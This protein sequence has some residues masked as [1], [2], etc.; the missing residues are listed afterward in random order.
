[1][2][3]MGALAGALGPQG[4]ADARKPAPS[5]SA[6]RPSDIPARGW[7]QIAKR[8][9]SEFNEDHIEIIAAGVTFHFLLAIF[10]GIAA[11]V[12]LW[13][14]VGDVAQA[15]RQLATLG[16]IL[17]HDAI[18][19]VGEQMRRL[20]QAHPAG[21]SLTVAFGLLVSLWSANGATRA[22][23]IGLN[24]AAEEKE[25]R[26]PVVLTLVSLAFTLAII[27]L[28]AVITVALGAG[29]VVGAFLGPAAR[30]LVE[31]ARWP[32]LLLLFAGGLCILYRYGPSRPPKRWRW[33]TWGSGGATMLWLA[34]SGGISVWLGHFAHLDRTYG[35]LGAVIGLMLWIWLSAIIVLGGAEL[36]AEIEREAA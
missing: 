18:A 1:M 23:I 13:G 25:T 14:L 30:L 3:V 15:E 6:D 17:P 28:L 2:A 5:R 9:W 35:P 8:V 12:A 11:F 7:R 21:L 16:S 31:I 22:L 32:A 10:P 19:F 26:G 33:I 34:A 36:N 24:V 29:A 27:A 4:A 20:S